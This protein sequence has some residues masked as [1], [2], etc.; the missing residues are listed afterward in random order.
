MS[1]VSCEL[2]RSLTSS[3]FCRKLTLK[4]AGNSCSRVMA[5]KPSGKWDKVA[6]EAYA[7]IEWDEYAELP[8]GLGL[9][10]IS[11][12]T[13]LMRDDRDRLAFSRLGGT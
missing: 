7:K 1:A 3:I 9:S 10:T 8:T 4:P 12:L 5:Q 13:M 2:M 6:G 11:G